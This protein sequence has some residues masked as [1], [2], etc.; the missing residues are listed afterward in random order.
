MSFCPPAPSQLGGNRSS[1]I[2]G[3]PHHSCVCEEISFA[4]KGFDDENGF[5]ATRSVMVYKVVSL[6]VRVLSVD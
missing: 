3:Q 1:M 6:L 4:F 2:T 5:I